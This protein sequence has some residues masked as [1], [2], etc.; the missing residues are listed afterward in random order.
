MRAQPSTAAKR[1]QESGALREDAIYVE[2]RADQELY[3]ALKEGE[4]CAVLAPR[5][6]GKSSLRVH[7]ARRLQ[8][9]GV[10][11]AQIDLTALG[12][13]ADRDPVAAWYFSLAS[14]VARELRLADPKSFFER[15][16]DRLP[17][18]RF[19]LY[20]REEVLTALPGPV[21]LFV[22]EIDYLRSHLFDRDELFVA[23]RA[24]YNERAQRPELERLTFCLLGVAAPRDLVKNPDI[25]P[26]NIGRS[27]HLA[28]FR[29]DE[30][31]PFAAPLALLG[32][33]PQRWLDEIYRWTSGHPYMTQVLCHFLLQ[34]RGLPGRIAE[35]V[36][37]SVAVRFLRTG[38][39]TDDNLSYA[40]KRL[41]L[42]EHKPTL[43]ALYRQILMHRTVLLDRE[44]PVQQELQLCGLASSH[45]EEDGR[46]Q[47]RVRNQIFARV[48]DLEWVL[49][50][51]SQRKLIQQMRRWQS[52]G[53]QDAMLLGGVD[54][55]EAGQWVSN[56]AR[57]VTAEEHEFLRASLDGARRM[58]ERERLASEARS[59]RLALRG[60]SVFIAVL[61]ALLAGLYSQY[62]RAQSYAHSEALAAAEA[63]RQAQRAQ[64]ALRQARDERDRAE[65][66]AS[67]AHH[68]K[69][70]A[71]EHARSEKAANRKAQLAAKAADYANRLS[72]RSAAEARAAAAAERQA[73]KEAELA[74]ARAELAAAQTR[75]SAAAERQAKQDAERHRMRAEQAAEKEYKARQEAESAARI[76][77]SLRAA[78][79]ATQPE[80]QIQAL[81]AGMQAAHGGSLS[82]AW[83]G[84]NRAAELIT[85][86]RTVDGHHA[87]AWSVAYSPDGSRMVTANEE[88]L[89]EVWDAASGRE[90]LRLKGHT[91][92]VHSA[93]YSFDGKRI[94]T[95]SE[96]RTARIWD[97]RTGALLGQLIGH[98][99]KVLGAAFSHDG[100]LVVTASDDRSARIW[101]ARTFEL[102]R[103][104]SGHS[105]WVW[106]AA[107]SPS[108]RHV[109][110]ASVD[111]TARIWEVGSGKLLHVLRGHDASVRSAAYSPSGELIVTASADQTARVW[112]ARTGQYLRGI[113][114]HGDDLRS[115]EFSPDERYIL[116][117]SEDATARL[118]DSRT[119]K[120]VASLEGHASGVRAATMSPR[121]LQVATVSEDST[122]RVWDWGRSRLLRRLDAG[123]G[124]IHA[125]AYSPDG[126]QLATATEAAVRLWDSETGQPS[127]P[128]LLHAEAVL[129]VRYS[130]N[131]KWLAT[132]SS[133]RVARIWS[134]ESGKIMDAMDGHTD[135]LRAVAF[136][137]GGELL[138]TASDDGSARIWP[139]SAGRL[140]MNESWMKFTVF[141]GTGSAPPPP[142]APARTVLSGHAAS[143]LAIAYAH[144]GRH[145]L[146]GSADHSAVIWSV[147]TGQ[148]EFTL[149]GHTNR[150]LAVAYSPDDRYVATASDDRTARIWYAAT[151]QQRLVLR[152][153]TDWVRS[154]VFSRDGRYLVTASDDHT[155]SVWDAESGRL[156]ISLAGHRGSVLAAAFSPDGRYVATG[157]AD[158]T[159]LIHPIDPAEI[160]AFA[161]R[162]LRTVSIPTGVSAAELKS[163]LAGCKS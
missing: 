36:A 163:L 132:A 86:S 18:D 153:H 65:Q 48:F 22:D 60:V 59:Q 77:K 54:L 152:G 103:R 108:D 12:R 10:H 78:I 52:A 146:T 139:F 119:A 159:A 118:W 37:D 162:F 120:P 42:S 38:R 105:L 96:D 13:A 104:L 142:S 17:A 15:T 69:D 136:S 123:S 57:E 100:K 79:M 126:K 84:L 122:L 74:Q 161:C 50:K 40:E 137:P 25:T 29:R 90:L 87:S 97:A 19:G 80:K 154:V 125:V 155:A 158:G 110:T 56:H 30:I 27:I 20:L 39:G 111:H 95:A 49:G 92:C 68:Q 89:A 6:I 82:P 156:L 99:G 5:Q 9:A 149:H 14:R 115:A 64:D 58:A 128:P 81:V 53:R 51:E 47:L 143:V 91:A 129:D 101:D 117:A 61:L 114:G 35:Q 26:F 121:G 7:T 93:R 130:P 145:I 43:L 94:V 67:D 133:D 98:P 46:H 131:G 112:D 138:A 1:L 8:N 45:R 76:E 16:R 88:G 21:V 113:S 2:R 150:I 127:R 71:E 144:D 3:R 63:K 72:A 28:D 41:D 31:A 83:E 55:T 32:G 4:F 73:K 44:D 70:L 124:P 107:F 24:L 106:M 33:D 34:Q 85:L 140:Q 23:I 135:W 102:K 109:V 141:L 134:L 157:G 62:R 160:Y 151:G 11:C 147:A 75:E 148:R 116:T 66:A